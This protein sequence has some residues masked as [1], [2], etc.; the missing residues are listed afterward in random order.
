MTSN[1]SLVKAEGMPQ[2]RVQKPS[3]PQYHL[4]KAVSA[5]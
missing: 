1:L 5:V 3:F 4:E 2:M